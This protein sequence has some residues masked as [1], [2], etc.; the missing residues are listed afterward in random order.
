MRVGVFKVVGIG[1]ERDEKN[2]FVLLERKE[3]KGIGLLGMEK[4]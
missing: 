1:K 4:S 3:K 2:G